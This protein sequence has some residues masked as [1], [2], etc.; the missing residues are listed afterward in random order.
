MSLQQCKVYSSL[1]NLELASNESQKLWNRYY[2]AIKH[3]LLVLEGQR[4]TLV[5]INKP[6]LFPSSGLFTIEVDQK[7]VISARFMGTIIA[8]DMSNNAET[9]VRQ[10]RSRKQELS[11]IKVWTSQTRGPGILWSP[12]HPGKTG[13][14]WV[15]P[16]VWTPTKGKPP[17]KSPAFGG[18]WREP[19]HDL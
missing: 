9:R 18:P 4:Q 19:P 7:T 11:R 14:W 10:N 1:I 15:R 2:W 3:L 13:F 12:R 8:R 16:S 17:D 6:L 5:R